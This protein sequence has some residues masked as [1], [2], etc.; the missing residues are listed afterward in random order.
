MEKR[1]EET[2]EESNI[3][4]DTPELSVVMRQNKNYSFSVVSYSSPY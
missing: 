1:N 4:K 3:L 2:H